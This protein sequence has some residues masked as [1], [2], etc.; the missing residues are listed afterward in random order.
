M[1]G[2]MS[3]PKVAAELDGLMAGV[4]KKAL[5]A[6]FAEAGIASN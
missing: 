3:D 1:K 2:L 6:L 4:D 5:E